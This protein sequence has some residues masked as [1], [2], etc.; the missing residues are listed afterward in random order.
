MDP[1]ELFQPE[2]SAK[3]A[4]NLANYHGL[5]MPFKRDAFWIFEFTEK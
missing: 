1:V 2:L 3:I 5:N 4:E